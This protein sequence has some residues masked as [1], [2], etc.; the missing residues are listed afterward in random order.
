MTV[1]HEGGW[2][3]TQTVHNIYTHLATQDKNED[4]ERMKAFYSKPESPQNTTE[5][6]IVIAQPIAGAANLITNGFT[7]E[8]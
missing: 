6:V 3:N 8:S 5:T 1:M 2:S 4:I 7:N